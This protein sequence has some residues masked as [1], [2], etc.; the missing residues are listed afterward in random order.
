[1]HAARM[2]LTVAFDKAWAFSCLDGQLI[3]LRSESRHF[4][5]PLA[6]QLVLSLKSQRLPPPAPHRGQ[7][8]H[9][10]KTTDRGR[11]DDS[12]LTRESLDQSFQR[13]RAK[14]ESADAGGQNIGDL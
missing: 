14:N 12:A 3:I 5:Q 8:I 2:R 7:Y 13:F 1:M 11:L 4:R 10:Q 9:Q 6:H